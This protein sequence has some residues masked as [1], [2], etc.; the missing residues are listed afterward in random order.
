MGFLGVLKGIGKGIGGLTGITGGI[1]T[2]LAAGSQAQANNRGNKFQ[3]Q[4]D[5]ATLLNQRDIANA[6]LA[7]QADND[8]VKN[9]IA[10]EAEGRAGREDAWRKLQSAQHVTNPGTQPNLSPYAIA[11][12][13]HTDAEK[14]AATA[15]SE[16]V[17]NRLLTGNPME[18]VTRRAPGL[19]FD[20]TAMVDLGL[21]DPSKSEKV[22]GWLGAILRGIGGSGQQNESGVAMSGQSGYTSPNVTSNMRF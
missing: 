18:A 11:P 13:E 22:T 8:F 5:F 10:R 16:E 4:L 6:Q 7:A 17:R 9:T 1:G 3:G 12:R 14:T 21:L 20:P 19:Q 15:L 2:G